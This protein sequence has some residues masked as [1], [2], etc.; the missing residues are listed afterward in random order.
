MIKITIM[1][2]NVEYI[3]I[4]SFNKM[5]TKASSAVAYDFNLLIYT[6]CS[7]PP[8]RPTDLPLPRRFVVLPRPVK[9]TRPNW[10]R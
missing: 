6:V 9:K 8:P 7:P 2:M 4:N 3:W 10:T 1:I 5:Q